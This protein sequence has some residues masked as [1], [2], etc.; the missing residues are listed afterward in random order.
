MAT[1]PASSTRQPA[2]N[3]NMNANTSNGPIFIL[4]REE[5]ADGETDEYTTGE[6][7]GQTEH[8]EQEHVE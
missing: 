6:G 5:P 1:I 4:L 2:Q 3:R 8:D 7:S